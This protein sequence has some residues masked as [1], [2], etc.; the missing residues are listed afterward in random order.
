MLARCLAYLRVFFFCNKLNCIGP[1]KIAC[2]SSLFNSLLSFV[3]LFFLSFGFIFLILSFN[4]RFLLNFMLVYWIYCKS[5]FVFFYY[6]I[7]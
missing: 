3:G 1:L 6:I 4:V 5:I 7:K 2:L